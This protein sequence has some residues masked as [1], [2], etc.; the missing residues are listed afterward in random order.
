MKIFLFLICA[1]VAVFL[2]QSP[3]AGIGTLQ[4]SAERREICL[5]ALIPNGFLIVDYKS[6]PFNCPNSPGAFN[7]I[8]IERF[9]GRPA[10]SRMDICGGQVVPYGW[11]ITSDSSWDPRRCRTDDDP[12]GGYH[13][14]IQRSG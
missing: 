14:K 12:Q 11:R 2:M 6:D 4:G 8:V 13:A 7:K 5:G 9:V 10:G 1:V 3:A